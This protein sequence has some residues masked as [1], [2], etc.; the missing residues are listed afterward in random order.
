MTRK[1]KDKLK[2]L[3]F[4]DRVKSNKKKQMVMLEASAL[5]WIAVLV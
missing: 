5:A 4:E 3:K 2:T 1:I